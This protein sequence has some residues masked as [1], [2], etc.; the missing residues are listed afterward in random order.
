MEMVHMVRTTTS[1]NQQRLFHY[2]KIYI[3]ILLVYLGPQQYRFPMLVASRHVVG[4]VTCKL[5]RL[6]QRASLA[7]SCHESVGSTIIHHH[8]PIML[9]YFGCYT[10]E[11]NIAASSQACSS[12]HSTRWPY[13]TPWRLFAGPQ[14]DILG[15]YKAQSRL[16]GLVAAFL[17]FGPFLSSSSRNIKG[18]PTWCTR[19][20]TSTASP[21][22]R[23]LVVACS[24]ST[25]RP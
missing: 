12:S 10:V 5:S 9:S 4:S 3:T 8:P 25:S 20:A 16:F 21:P 18:W 13:F 1:T 19:L 2:Q 24:D 15:T 14:G 7:Q 23:S 22:L 17:F 11:G 6:A